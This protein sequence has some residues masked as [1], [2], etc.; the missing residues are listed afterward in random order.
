VSPILRAFVQLLINQYPPGAGIGWHRDRPQ[1][2][3][4]AGVSF[5]APAEMRFRRDRP[6]GGWDRALLPLP[7]RSAYVL[8]GDARSDWLHSIQPGS[9]LRYSATFRTLRKT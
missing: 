9:A 3:V 2:G 5:G 1:F 6:G 7:P 8:D 4:V